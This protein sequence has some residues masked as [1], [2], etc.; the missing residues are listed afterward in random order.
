MTVY[1][2]AIAM[3]VLTLGVMF[4]RMLIE[5]SFEP[6]DATWYEAI[7]L[8]IIVLGTFLILQIEG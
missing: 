4:Q 2:I 7:F 3:L 5:R 6:K 1:N 8:W